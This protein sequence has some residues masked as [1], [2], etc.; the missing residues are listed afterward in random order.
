[1]TAYFPITVTC[2]HCGARSSH[3]RLG[4]VTSSGY[5]DLDGR[6]P[7]RARGTMAVWLQ[8]CPSCLYV[9]RDISSADAQESD[10]VRHIGFIEA[11]MSEGMP[12]LATRFMRRAYIDEQIGQPREAIKRLL[13]AA[14][15]LDDFE[16]D[17]TSVRARAAEM[18][19]AIGEAADTE[20]RLLR[21]DLLR[22]TAAFKETISEAD[23]L[24]RG[25]LEPDY[26]K[27]AIGQRWAAFEK[28]T[29]AI[30]LSEAKNPVPRR[31][32]LRVIVSPKRDD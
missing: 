10:A 1:M 3:E 20:L 12:D 24:L 4:S 16:R 2:A 14:W 5:P 21:L 17:A 8:E 31:G 26:R 18:I 6:P 13:H 19:L 7:W 28:R 27:V 9:A 30:S 22:R 23:R 29:G 11:G 25:Q 15:V 32:Q